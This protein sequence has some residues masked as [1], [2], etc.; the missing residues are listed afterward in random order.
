M[1]RR[2]ALG[3]VL[4][5]VV[6]VP[7]AG[8]WTWP[9]DGDVVRGFS[10][11]ESHPYA[12]DQHRGIDVA[13]GGSA[14]VVAPVSGAVS[15]AGSVPNGGL[16]VTI[17]TDDGFSVTLLHLGSLGV[18]R[19]SI[20]NE[21]E[22][23]GGV[24]PTGDAEVAGPYVHL[25]VRLTADPNGYLDPLSFL[26]PRLVT[27][28]PAPAPSPA[29]APVPVSAPV[30]TP[31]VSTT[32][33]SAPVPAPPAVS[34]PATSAASTAA[35]TE[36]PASSPAVGETDAG[37]SAVAA[38]TETTPAETAPSNDGSPT[39]TAPPE[40]SAPPAEAPPAQYG[41]GS[42]PAPVPVPAAG[43]AG[44]AVPGSAA[45]STAETST[46]PVQNPPILEPPVS[47]PAPAEPAAPSLSPA[48]SAAPRPAV[49]GGDPADPSADDAAASADEAQN[50]APVVT[51]A[52]AEPVAAT[53]STARGVDTPT[54]APAA[55]PTNEPALSAPPTPVDGTAAAAAVATKAVPAV[56]V[57]ATTSP[58]AAPTLLAQFVAVGLAAHRVPPTA[59]ERQAPPT[60]PRP[61][62]SSRDAANDP[63]AKPRL[64]RRPLLG[65]TAFG[66]SSAP[67][68]TAR[69]RTSVLL[70]SLLALLAATAFAIAAKA[71]RMISARRP[72]APL[73]PPHVE[74]ALA[75]AESAEDPGCSRVAVREW[76]AAHRPRG[77]IRRPV[78]HLR[79][80]P[81]AQGQ[82]RP[83]GERDGRARDADHG[84]GRN[85]G[86]LAA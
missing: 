15:F 40:T 78:R 64:G 34:A 38:A 27:S 46:T 36:A 68:T 57:F 79:A 5:L 33:A 4:F 70:R 82:R 14:S 51:P 50:S 55:V 71:A 44:S 23:V 41:T 3:A 86:Q 67:A 21:G 60:T 18:S 28:A 16:A 2:A 26:P 84:R 35:A 6:F 80:V 9:V 7:A 20:V 45:S 76:S 62:A 37:A 8:A 43:T 77:G 53:T 48:P 63:S 54:D 29:P 69:R 65:P 30:Q 83:D 75:G 25:G 81:P 58:F 13:A 73:V 74:G 17:R 42:E 47:T 11:D 59:S 19:G 85:R 52:A 61:E 56:P 1:L 10:Y 66:I 32:D 22:S 31:P 39:A 12:G 72:A 24:G 49:L